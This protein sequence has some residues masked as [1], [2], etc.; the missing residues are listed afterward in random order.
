MSGLSESVVK[1]FL[2]ERLHELTGVRNTN[3]WHGRLE[4]LLTKP[5]TEGPV[6]TILFDGMNQEPSVAWLQILKIL[7][8][9]AFEGRI[10]VLTSTRTHYFEDRLSRL[11]GLIVPAVP[12]AVEVYDPSPGGEL[13]RMLAFEGL[14]RDDLHPDL[15]ELARTPRLFKLVVRFRERLV[16]AGQSRRV[17]RVVRLMVRLTTMSS[18]KD[19][20][21]RSTAVSTTAALR[22]SGVVRQRSRRFPVRSARPR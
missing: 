1:R 22:R 7:Q 21:S 4:H 9:P 12:I 15:V 19:L 13:D 16:E 17:R 8:G 18:S 2:A 14:T 11:R 10:R 5:K 20:T 3:H 6:L